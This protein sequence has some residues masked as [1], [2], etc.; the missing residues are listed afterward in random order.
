LEEI[1]KAGGGDEDNAFKWLE[2]GYVERDGVLVTLKQ[3]PGW[4]P[5]RTDPRYFDLVRR[6]WI[7][8]DLV[9]VGRPAVGSLDSVLSALKS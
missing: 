6:V 3:N 8:I 1:H 9:A 4:A 5:L 2:T 7:A